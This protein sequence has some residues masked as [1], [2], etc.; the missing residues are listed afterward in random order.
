M[1]YH[2][3]MILLENLKKINKKMKRITAHIQIN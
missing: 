1:I 3:I 2:M